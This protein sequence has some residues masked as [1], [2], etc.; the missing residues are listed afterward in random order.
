MLSNKAMFYFQKMAVTVDG[1]L[2]CMFFMLG[3]IVMNS[4]F[5][6]VFIIPTVIVF[7]FY[8]FVQRFYVASSRYS[9]NSDINKLKC[10]LCYCSPFKTKYKVLLFEIV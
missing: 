8:I 6:P 7:V 5:T 9:L 4:I 10:K 1:V 3:G 2:F